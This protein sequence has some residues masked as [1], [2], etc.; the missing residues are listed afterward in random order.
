VSGKPTDPVARF[1]RK[2][3]KNGP[4]LNLDLGPCWRWLGKPH[5]SGYG[6]H[7]PAPG[8]IAYAHRFAYA[9]LVGPIAEDLQLDHLCRNTMCVRPTHLEAVTQRVN[10][11]RS[12]SVCATNGR[13][14]HC[15]AGHP[16]TGDNVRAYTILSTGTVGRRCRACDAKR[17]REY[18][19]RRAVAA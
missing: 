18:R 6:R 14:L 13:K 10:N 8:T 19:A 11:A 9:L 4:V 12:M 15:D 16:L 7:S 5:K 2:V 3:D 1:W 17:A